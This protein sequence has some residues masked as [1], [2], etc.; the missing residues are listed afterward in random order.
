MDKATNP[1]LLTP[2]VTVP[3]NNW[4]APAGGFQVCDLF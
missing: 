3:T 2:G 4:E 1:Y